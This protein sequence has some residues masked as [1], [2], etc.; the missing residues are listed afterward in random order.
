M[1][2][3]IIILVAVIIL[4]SGVVGSL[5]TQKDK[6]G[7]GWSASLLVNILAITLCFSRIIELINE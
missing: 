1:E 3:R 6:S 2:T 7:L 4:N 5:L